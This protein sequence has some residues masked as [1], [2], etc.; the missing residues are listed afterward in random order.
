MANVDWESHFES[1]T[2][3]KSDTP[4]GDWDN[5]TSAGLSFM[6]AGTES[7]AF[8]SYGLTINVPT[9]GYS[10][11]YLQNNTDFSYGSGETVHVAFYVKI[12]D[13]HE[14]NINESL[15]IFNL[16]DSGGTYFIRVEIAQI[17]GGVWA[18]EREFYIQHGT[19]WKNAQTTITAQ[20]GQ[21]YLIEVEALIGDVGYAK[22]YI[23]N[24]L[25]ATTSAGDTW[26]GD[27][28]TDLRIF[29]RFDYGRVEESGATIYYDSVRIGN[30][31][32]I[33]PMSVEEETAF[34]A[35]FFGTNFQG[36]F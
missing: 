15:T 12:P 19:S 1:G 3:L 10:A 26:N 27:P 22:L 11:G 9:S 28:Y 24:N 21:W 32:M 18:D 30:D 33:G 23:D 8:G 5:D 36:Q 35:I 16:Y 20:T 2:L 25:E 13:G 6:S 14:W 17:G 31:G 34:N 7:A 29:Q 4:V